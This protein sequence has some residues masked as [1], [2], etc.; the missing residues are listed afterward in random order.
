M[1]ILL[2]ILTNSYFPGPYNLDPALA[3]PLHHTLQVPFLRELPANDLE[4]FVEHIALTLNLNV[5]Q[6]EVTYEAISANGCVA[7]LCF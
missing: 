5:T 1:C 4:A 2:A 3:A 6:E 7:I